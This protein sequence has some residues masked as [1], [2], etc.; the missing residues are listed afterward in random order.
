MLLAPIDHPLN[1][2]MQDVLTFGSWGLTAAL[3]AYAVRKGLREQTWFHPLVVLAA[4][5]AAFAEPLYDVAMDL[6]FY[7]TP[8]MQT[9]FTA[10]GIPQPVWTHSGYA[11]LYA[12]AALFLADRIHRG[13]LT[14]R[15]L[16]LG[17]G[18]ELLMSCTFEMVGINGD[19]YAYWGAH[20][21]RIF[22]YPLVIGVLEAA[23]VATFAVVA[24]QVRRRSTSQLGLLALFPL[25]PV[26]FFGVNFGCGFPTIVSIHLES[27]S[28]LGVALASL[29]SM[30]LAA[31]VVRIASTFLPTQV[32][33]IEQEPAPAF[34]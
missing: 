23:Q 30:A 19:T 10:F 12:S 25:F 5:V 24:S 18:L 16:F 34:A 26:V 17:A 32:E 3:L 28:R 15:G 29:V 21:F 20:E 11:V 31:G 22:H 8:D 13:V 14:R 6:Y 27:H 4:M 9:H 2:T 7:S 1:Q 33:G